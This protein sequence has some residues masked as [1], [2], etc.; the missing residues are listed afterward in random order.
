MHPNQV[1][2]RQQIPPHGNFTLPEYVDYLGKSNNINH[3]NSPTTTTTTNANSI[4]SNH[5]HGGASSF[6]PRSAVN[7][8]AEPQYPQRPG[9]VLNLGEHASHAINNSHSHNNQNTSSNSTVNQPHNINNNPNSN[10]FSYQH[11]HLS[12]QPSMTKMSKFQI[13]H[14]FISEES[15]EKEGELAP[16]THQQQ[17]PNQQHLVSPSTH[18]SNSK[19][20]NPLYSNSISDLNILG[21]KNRISENGINKLQHANSYHMDRMDSHDKLAMSTH[22]QTHQHHQ[23]NDKLR[24]NSNLLLNQPV[25][26]VSPSLA[27]SNSQK[28]LSSNHDLNNNLPANIK[29]TCI[30]SSNLRSPSCNNATDL[31]PRSDNPTPASHQSHVN[32][33]LNLNPNQSNLKINVSST[34]TS[35]KSN[36]TTNLIN[37]GNVVLRNKNI[38]HHNHNNHNNNTNWNRSHTN[39]TSS[40]PSKNLDVSMYPPNTIVGRENLH[41]NG[42]SHKSENLRQKP[43]ETS[44]DNMC[45]DSGFGM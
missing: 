5:H 4:S 37:T 1:N 31:D 21:G 9:R 27:S 7:S 20:I 2:Y 26:V 45:D 36:S 44:F 19:F 32:L 6:Y 12:N 18:A 25:S 34:S 29:N 42:A 13:N 41:L 38:N 22:A 30:S 10:N 40:I 23:Q 33:N 43:L 14:D 15:Y 35:H 28:K 16:P 24:N 39:P 11:Q 8:T 3:T 17:N